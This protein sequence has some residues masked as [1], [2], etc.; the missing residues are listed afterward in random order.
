[1]SGVRE[2][3]IELKVRGGRVSAQTLDCHERLNFLRNEAKKSFGINFLP[4]SC[5]PFTC[6]RRC[7]PELSTAR[8]YGSPFA[9]LRAWRDIRGVRNLPSTP[10][11]STV[12][13][14]ELHYDRNGN[15]TF[16]RSRFGFGVAK[17]NSPDREPVVRNERRQAGENFSLWRTVKRKTANEQWKLTSI[18]D[19]LSSDAGHT[20][21]NTR[22]KR[23]TP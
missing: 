17:L 12:A 9:P 16:H 23:T 6:K 18:C 22:V 14:R 13:P 7:S 20:Y 5:S 2:G 19:P 1:M 11:T 15:E 4:I 3:S 10:Q 21:A 8:P